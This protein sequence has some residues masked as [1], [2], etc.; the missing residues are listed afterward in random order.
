MEDDDTRND[1]GSGPVVP[2]DYI[3]SPDTN[4]TVPTGP[5]HQNTS[6]PTPS[7]ITEQAA[8]AA[9][10]TAVRASPL[11]NKCL[12]YTVDATE[13]YIKGCVDDIKVTFSIGLSRCTFSC[14]RLSWLNCQLRSAR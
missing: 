1:I 3:T 7:G 8:T 4:Y 13:A 2:D 12:Q 14:G 10:D 9:C 6:W 11:Y 5:L